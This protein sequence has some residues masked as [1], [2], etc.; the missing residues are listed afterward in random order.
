M[1]LAYL[2]KLRTVKNVDKL[3]KGIKDLELMFCGCISLEDCMDIR[4][5]VS[6]MMNDDMSTN[7]CSKAE[8][9]LSGMFGDCNKLQAIKI[10]NID[11]TKFKHVDMYTMYS[12]CHNVTQIDISNTKF[13]REKAYFQ[14]IFFLCCSVKEIKYS[15]ED[16][17]TELN[18][19]KQKILD[20]KIVQDVK[21]TKSN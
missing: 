2:K 4:K 19:L 21:L 18:K 3:I 20:Y 13:G 16:Q 8:L 7:N 6:A 9:V 10:N 14:S 5:I 1:A 17:E 11:F 15:Y 12:G